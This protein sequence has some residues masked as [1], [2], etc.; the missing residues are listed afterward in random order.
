MYAALDHLGARE[1]RLG[2][3]TCFFIPFTCTSSPTTDYNDTFKESK[4]ILRTLAFIASD[5][6]PLY[7]GESP[8]GLIAEQ[9]TMASGHAG[10]NVEYVTRLAEY[11]RQHLPHVHDHHLF[12]LDTLIREILD[13]KGICINCLIQN[14]HNN[15]HHQ[16][17]QHNGHHQNG[18]HHKGQHNGQPTTLYAHSQWKLYDHDTSKYSLQTIMTIN[19]HH[20]AYGGGCSCFEELHMTSI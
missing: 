4:D 15:G 19:Q 6:N 10:H 3:Y 1:C 16:N 12:S 18:Q 8:L 2:G 17:G 11:T 20:Q 13:E 5:K 9:V 7:L 14:V